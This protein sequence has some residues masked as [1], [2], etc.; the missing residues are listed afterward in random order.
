MFAELMGRTPAYACC[1]W[2]RIHFGPA[3]SPLA[4]TS[5]AIATRKRSHGLSVMCPTSYRDKH[6]DV[7]TPPRRSRQAKH[8]VAAGHLCYDTGACLL[9]HSRA[10][11][12]GDWREITTNAD[13]PKDRRRRN[14]STR[15]RAVARYC[16]ALLATLLC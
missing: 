16:V 4:N 8:P 14:T 9:V 13:L 3:S 5:R 2:T 15:R 6:V 7:R 11:T 10:W 1:A 12:D